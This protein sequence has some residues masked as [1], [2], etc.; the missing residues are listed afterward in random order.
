MGIIF[1]MAI[2]ISCFIMCLVV[3]EHYTLNILTDESYK[4]ILISLI[5]ITVLM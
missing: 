2:I 1:S 3:I 4:N 5:I